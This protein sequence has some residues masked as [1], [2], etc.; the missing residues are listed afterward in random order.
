[1]LVFS[2]IGLFEE[3]Y[4]ATVKRYPEIKD[5]IIVVSLDGTSDLKVYEGT[6]EDSG[7]YKLSLRMEDDIQENIKTIALGLAMIICD[8]KYGKYDANNMTEEQQ[9]QLVEVI[10]EII[11]EYPNV[12][13]HG[14]LGYQA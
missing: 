13:K 14:E 5:V 3:V 6:H 8:F 4:D 7:K 11:E 12:P 2:H 10:K 9:I 1:M